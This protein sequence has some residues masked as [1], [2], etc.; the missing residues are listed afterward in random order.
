MA[1]RAG[2]RDEVRQ[3][4]PFDDLER[5]TR[6]DVLAWIDSG[7]ELCRVQKPATPP[8]H[9]ISYFVVVDGE[10][11]LLVDHLNAG[12]WLPPGGHVEPD[13]HP[14]DTVRREC[15]EEL[16]LE[17]GDVAD[18]CPIFV[19]VTET[20]GNAP[21]HT[22]VSLWYVIRGSR[23][24]VVEWQ[25]TIVAFAIGNS[26]N[27]SIWALFT[28][29][30]HEGQGYGRQLHDITVAWLW[31]QGHR[32]LWLTTEQGT[33]AERFYRAAGWKRIGE[34]SGDEVRFGLEKPGQP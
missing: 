26:E 2:I 34:D 13:E 12:L 10:Y 16:F 21:G 7:A 1:M 9:L 32:Q 27:G 17:A 33:R 15:M 30:D 6:A 5:T 25:G 22:D 19:T 28:E 24:W 18:L 11:V 29:P 23:G 20:V 8:K 4:D 31:E 3:I 14:R